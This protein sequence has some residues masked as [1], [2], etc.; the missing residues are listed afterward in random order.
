MDCCSSRNNVDRLYAY[1]RSKQ[2]G[3]FL[4]TAESVILSLTGDS[5]VPQ[6]KNIQ[7]IIHEVSDPA[8]LG[9]SQV[10]E[11]KEEEKIKSKL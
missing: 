6:F 8:G 9:Q 3:A 7:K 5:R 10:R 11:D 1:D 2:I 4:N